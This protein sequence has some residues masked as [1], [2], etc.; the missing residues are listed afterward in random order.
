MEDI[1]LKE[2]WANY[3]KKLEKALALNHRLITEIQAQ[4][5]RSVLRPL[6]TVKAIAV[7]SGLIWSL[8]LSV[9]VF[10]AISDM[11][12]YRLFF[13]ISA[14]SIVLLTVAAIVVYIRQIVLIQQIDNNMIIVEAQRKLAALQ[15]ST[16]NIARLLF[17]SAP[18]YTTFYF[19]KSMFEHGTIGLWVFQ[20]TVT[21][22]FA[23]VSIWLYR[24]IK[25]ENAGKRWFKIIFG[26]SEWTSVIKAMNFLKEIEAYE[27]E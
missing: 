13:I 2:M 27:K 6:K 12:P 20:L 15:S 22:A 11:T 23:T 21:A 17:L 3:D 26:T 18:F 4:K 19:N 5:A 8:F 7:V 1:A 24:N 16:I 14:L 10:F 9:L 25:M